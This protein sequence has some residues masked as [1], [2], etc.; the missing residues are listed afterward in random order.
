MRR[1]QRARQGRWDQIE[2]AA[3]VLLCG[4]AL[5]DNFSMPQVVEDHH[6]FS[7]A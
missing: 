5:L 6:F 1:W 3:V 2:Q 7:V 4:M